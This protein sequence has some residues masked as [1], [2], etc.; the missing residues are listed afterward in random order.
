[1]SSEAAM[2][3]DSASHVRNAARVKR[4][5][6]ELRKLM[7]EARG[8]TDEESTSDIQQEATE[9]VT[10][11]EFV[12]KEDTNDKPEE[13][14][15]EEPQLSKEE[16]SFKKR[17]GDLRRHLQEKEQEFKVELEK[18][19][20]QLERST[21]NELVL[22]KSEDEI[23]AWAKKYP[24]V[25]GIVEAIADKKASERSSDLDKRLKEIEDLRVQA[26]KD[27]AE[28]ELMSLHPDFTEIR[29]DDEFHEWAEAQPKW[30]QDALYENVDD[31]KSVAR[32]IDLYK[33][34]KGITKKKTTSEDKSA[35]SSVNAKT[36]N[37]PEAD[38]SKSYFRESQVNKMSTKEYEKNADAIMDAIRS[39]KFV[40]DVSGR[41]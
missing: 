16:E 34:D 5:E 2:T 13:S 7:A 40:Y 35:A 9:E 29:S 27:K 31:A 1:M 39:G 18:L 12:A 15:K 6:E 36:R 25:A 14:R 21:K 20:S 4:D 22:P 8:E 3:V 30:V 26:K 41:K 19:K 23:A 38:E 37:T 33:A 28:A 11:E 32:V 17:Y 24:D 10:Q